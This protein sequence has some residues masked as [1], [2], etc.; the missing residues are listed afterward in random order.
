MHWLRR[1]FPAPMNSHLSGIQMIIVWV[2]LRYYCLAPSSSPYL[3]SSRWLPDQVISRY[4]ALYILD[5]NTLGTYMS[6]NL[7]HVHGTEG[8]KEGNIL[9]CNLSS[10]LGCKINTTNRSIRY[11]SA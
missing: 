7:S 1:G 2:F 11:P 4:S 5:N 9:L 10:F 3:S 6:T 8:R